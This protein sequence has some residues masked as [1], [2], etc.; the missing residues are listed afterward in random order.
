MILKVIRGSF[1]DNDLDQFSG[2]EFSDQERYLQVMY[3]EHVDP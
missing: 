2:D 1:K 3:M